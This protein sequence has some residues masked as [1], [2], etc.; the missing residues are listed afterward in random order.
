MA[1]IGE[2]YHSLL[3]GRVNKKEPTKLFFSSDTGKLLDKSTTLGSRYW[4]RN[5]ESRVLCRAAFSSILQHPIGKHP[6]FVV[7][8]PHSALAGPSRQILTQE[9]VTAPYISALIRNQNGVESL[10]SSVGKLY[11]LQVPVN[12]KALIPTGSCLSDLPPYPWDHEESY[13]YEIRLTTE[14]S[15]SRDSRC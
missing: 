6:G 11:T 14:I 2:D 4:Q 15:L 5:M 9:S 13:W 10:L 7:I 1:E 3:E 12:L 8:G